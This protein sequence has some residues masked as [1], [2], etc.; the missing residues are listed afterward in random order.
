MMQS[1]LKLFFLLIFIFPS[2][3]QASSS[4]DSTG[5]SIAK[6]YRSDYLFDQR[7]LLENPEHQRCLTQLGYKA[8]QLPPANDTCCDSNSDIV[9]MD[10]FN[11]L[12]SLAAYKK[13]Q[14]AAEK[15]YYSRRRWMYGSAIVQEATSIFFL[16]A[17]LIVGYIIAQ[18]YGSESA[19][20]MLLTTAFLATVYSTGALR[21][22][23]SGALFPKNDPLTPYEVSYARRKPEVN[24]LDFDKDKLAAEEGFTC[25]SPEQ[26][27]LNARLSTVTL[28]ATIASLDILR[29][30]PTR[31][32]SFRLSLLDLE[33]DL[34]VYEQE[35]INKILRCCLNHEASYQE[36]FGM[37]RQRR[38][39]MMLIGPPGQGK[40]Y[41]VERISRHMEN[42]SWATLDLS[43]AT[44]ESLL[45]T[46]TEPGLLL[47]AL[48]Q[49]SHRNGILLI[50][51]LCH[52]VKNEQ[53]L[54]TLLTILDPTRKTFFSPFLQRT[55]DLSH[56]FVIVAGNEDLTQ[57]A[58]KSR[59]GNL[60]TVHM[61]IYDLTPYLTWLKFTYLKEKLGER[62]LSH[63]QM[64]EWH[65]QIDHHFRKSDIHSFREAA[66][67]VDILI[68]EYRRIHRMQKR[69][70]P[71]TGDSSNMVTLSEE[72][73][74]LQ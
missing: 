71:K 60:K 21:D 23:I 31:S 20:S 67:F 39:F 8:S 6:Y 69:I 70:P 62:T 18:A 10:Q 49:L 7:S 46:R 56:L 30:I 12:P 9:E 58:L 34:S 17:P 36:R 64:T 28:K 35:E 38:E 11:S 43:G 54:A 22:L 45:G 59:F 19:A 47:L 48:V 29:N 66:D 13:F 27:F 24:F 72:S 25:P 41:C 37:N 63:H 42:L 4:G 33:Q 51:E 5:R 61:T 53:L 73:I 3:L 52:V 74:L 68:G 16:A 2:P 44:P 15:E 55:I 1:L 14:D 26:D 32:H 50:D 65:T 57:I 40:T